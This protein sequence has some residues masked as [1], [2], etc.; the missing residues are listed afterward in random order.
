MYIERK[1]RMLRNKLII[2]KHN[3][4][5]KKLLTL[6]IVLTIAITSSLLYCVI[7][8][9]EK[10]INIIKADL[11]IDVGNSDIVIYPSR[12]SELPYYDARQISKIKDQV[13]YIVNVFR[14]YG[15]IHNNDS[16]ST[17]A[18]LEGIED[19]NVNL[20]NKVDIVE[21][22]F[23]NDW[24]GKGVIISRATA[25][26]LKLKLDDQL[27]VQYADADYKF[28]VQ[29]I[30]AN[31][32][33]FGKNEDK[34]VCEAATLKT[35]TNSKDYEFTNTYIKVKDKSKINSTIAELKT[36]YKD[37]TIEE[38]ILD[39]DIKFYTD[40]ITGMLLQVFLLS[41]CICVLILFTTYK[42][43]LYYRSY[44]I[45]ILRSIGLSRHESI[46]NLLYENLVYALFGV[47]GGAILGIL[48]DQIIVYYITPIYLRKTLEFTVNFKALIFMSL[49]SLIFSMIINSY[50][51]YKC[52]KFQIRNLLL[53][54]EK[55]YSRNKNR[56]YVLLFM[57][58][59]TMTMDI[60]SKTL[61]SQISYCILTCILL[62]TFMAAIPIIFNPIIRFLGW[63]GKRTNKN[64]IIIACNNLI[65]N[66]HVNFN[67]TLIVIGLSCFI[68]INTVGTAVLKSITDTYQNYNYEIEAYY[69]EADSLVGAI[70]GLHE[71]DQLL[72]IKTS[73]NI[74]IASQDSNIL[75]HG[76]KNKE[77]LN[78]F[79]LKIENDILESLKNGRNIIISR[80]L[81]NK[82][83]VKAG[84]NLQLIFNNKTFSY[85][86]IGIVDTNINYG[87]FS[88]IHENN[89]MNDF[90]EK[91]YRK[92]LIKTSESVTDYSKILD[93]L[94]K[95]D[96]E[97]NILTDEIEYETQ[98]NVSKFR[99]L[100]YFILLT[101]LVGMIGV[102]NNTIITYHE[103]KKELAI[104][105]SLGSSKK[106]LNK[107][108][109]MEYS[110]IG[111]AA[112]T[113]TVILVNM[114]YRIIPDIIFL[115]GFEI[116]LRF[117]LQQLVYTLIVSFGLSFIF[118]A[119]MRFKIKNFELIQHIKGKE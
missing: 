6:I 9:N 93:V 3:L 47:I 115:F 119:F 85:K 78:F 2:V 32:G 65:S 95:N 75:I 106:K 79:D 60:I 59:L 52:Y 49:F 13:E 94:H 18:L 117:G 109:M 108:L 10:L 77:Y 41:L 34:I 98:S 70:S 73:S 28:Y 58:V 69:N 8:V 100:D 1:R 114:L 116:K 40:R 64:T 74:K 101:M 87:N 89:L 97:V 55:I 51:I 63:F 96:T 107:I 50:F 54:T 12:Y 92:L 62:M 84:D 110:L 80:L 112:S 37:L 118:Y 22:D 35:I 38:S 4:L 29:K 72:P 56:Y 21:E 31:T 66:I 15:K 71:V 103:R 102:I 82:I 27:I 33:Y 14:A 57:M 90:D 53:G 105:R 81:S 91:E 7:A 30:A 20:F 11:T 67:I 68:V 61:K 99:I 113:F 104:F 46:K 76:Y 45:G 43:L 44:G 86:I 83:N 23:N 24:G 5:E 111:L 88:I 36:Y 48:A 39:S 19:D 16:Y 42:L 17:Q 26:K 25:Q